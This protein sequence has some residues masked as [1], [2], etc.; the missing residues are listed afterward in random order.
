M[1]GVIVREVDLSAYTSS[2]SST[3]VAMVGASTKGKVGEGVLIS[4]PNNYVDKFGIPNSSSMLGYSALGFLGQGNQVYI[5]RVAGESVST[6]LVTLTDTTDAPVCK[7]LAESP[8]TWL[9]GSTLTI[10][11]STA[12]SFKLTVVTS[13]NKSESFT[14]SLD[15]AS[16]NDIVSTLESKS[17]FIRAELI[18]GVTSPYP[19][20]KT[21]TYTFSGGHDGISSKE[22]TTS[23][24]AVASIKS[25]ETVDSTP[26]EALQI[27]W[28]V[29]GVVGNGNK[30]VI[31]NVNG[32]S[33]DIEVT[34][35]ASVQLE[36]YVGCN[37]LLGDP[38][39]V[40]N[41][42]RSS[43]RVDVS[44]SM[45]YPT[46]L[47]VGSTTLGGGSDGTTT[48]ANGLTAADVIGTNKSG[49]NGFLDT[50]SYDID[51]LMAPGWSDAAVVN[52]LISV[53]ET[54]GDS[55]ALIDPPVGLTPQDVV[56]WH[57]GVNSYSD[58]SAFNSSYAAIYYPWIQ[59]YDAYS[60][61]TILI[62]PSGHIAGQY[63]YTDKVAHP[64]FAPAGLN[65]G[66]LQSVLG[67]EYVV[68]PN[69]R[70]FLYETSG[71][72]INPIVKSRKDGIVIWGQ[73]TAQRSDSA[74]DRVNVRR[75]L[76]QAKKVVSASSQYITFEQNDE[77]T[78]K[79]WKDLVSPYFSR[80]KANRGLEKDAEI[81]MD[82]TTVTSWDINNKRMPG[83]IILT[84]TQT[85]E[86]IVLDF[87]LTSSGATYG[88]N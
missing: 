2:L 53:C 87:V 25:T 36:N 72:A 28:K 23:T 84:P 5:M 63:A 14:V 7:I 18:T 37:T 4:N 48:T 61:K 51:L 8:G 50:E 83:K 45:S 49:V 59:V 9:N 21:N 81:I 76:L 88:S 19:Q 80:V 79:Q 65:R 86:D 29:P 31:S 56:D 46:T 24:K 1:P 40:T 34:D 62:P 57:N 66:K 22:I 33:F 17:K 54:R 74:T 32:I 44:Y 20:I 16:S 73:K 69:E 13:D 27:T 26:K 15:P 39:F 12:S 35:A 52:K 42:M 71:N 85:A 67:V 3:T 47:A 70:T 75:L 78:W 11:D 82:S 10:T 30:I 77:F 55:M 58:H 60:N 68:D 43:S 6:S 64:W 38:N 41:K